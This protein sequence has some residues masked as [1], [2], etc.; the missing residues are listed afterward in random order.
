MM[1]R[2]A[3]LAFLAAA[4][5]VPAATGCSSDD[6]AAG[7]SGGS[8][9]G[10]STST[11][12]TGAG[13]DAPDVVD[14]IINEVSAAGDDWI[15]LV[16]KGSAPFDLGGYGVA[17]TDPDTGAPKV[18][19]AVRFPAGTTLG[20]GEHLLV[21]ADQATA[22]GPP[23][24]VCI[25]GGPD[26]C[27]YA[28][29]AVSAADGERIFVLSPDDQIVADAAYPANAVPL[30]QTWGRLPDTTGAF[31]PNAPTPGAANQGP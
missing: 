19:D 3:F 24:T 10:T 9:A 29:W 6:S 25:P 11:T 1:R 7:G 14:A 31:A 16:N 21:V 12:S 18:A 5:A 23:Q 26:T 17:D 20:P 8:G 27:W 15:E 4:A 30:G 2:L 28:T 22:P 13:G